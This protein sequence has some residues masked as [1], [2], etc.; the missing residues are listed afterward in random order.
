M[1]CRV[2]ERVVDRDQL[3]LRLLAP[4]EDRPG[5]RPADAAESVDADPYCHSFLL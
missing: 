5:E 3:D 2:A 1:V 4:G